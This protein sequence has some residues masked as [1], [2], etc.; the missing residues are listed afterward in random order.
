VRHLVRNHG[1]LG[2]LGYPLFFLKSGKDCLNVRARVA[3]S[4]CKLSPFIVHDSKIDWAHMMLACFIS[5]HLEHLEPKLQ[6]V[7]GTLSLDGH[8]TS[9]IV[10]G[11]KRSCAL[12]AVSHTL[13]LRHYIIVF[14]VSL[15]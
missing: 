15:C 5:E 14:V 1:D 13:Q 4:H 12:T 8:T 11:V 7:Y 6:S 9:G 2:K 10:L 3:T